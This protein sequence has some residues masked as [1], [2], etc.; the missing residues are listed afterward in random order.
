MR[1]E[2]LRVADASIM[3]SI[4]GGNT[5]AAPPAISAGG[6]PAGSSAT[7]RPREDQA[8]PRPRD[9]IPLFADV[10]PQ[11][12]VV[13]VS[14]AGGM[15]VQAAIGFSLD[16]L[17]R[18]LD[19]I[20]ANVEAAPIVDVVMPSG[21]V[22][23]D[24]TK[25]T[26]GGAMA[27]A[28]DCKRRSPRARALL[29]QRATRSPASPRARPPSWRCTWTDQ[30]SRRQVELAGYPHPGS[31]RTPSGPPPRESSSATPGA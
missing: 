20:E 16:E 10:H 29:D 18:C 19:H 3:P 28:S 1:L 7:E 4:T 22:K 11:R 31:S 9:D 30:V 26:G 6:A 13:A 25:V 21:F 17:K 14:R 5:N 2:G 12:V 23:P 8:L 24:G 15:G 27:A